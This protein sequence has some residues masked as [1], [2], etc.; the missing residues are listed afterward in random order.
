MFHSS[1]YGLGLR[2]NLPI[3]GLLACDDEP[4]ARGSVDVVLNVASAESEPPAGAVP[5][6]V[7]DD[8]LGD[9]PALKLYHQPD[10]WIFSYADGA[11]FTVSADGSRIDGSWPTELTLADA[12]VY[13]LGPVLAFVLRLRNVF[14]LHAGVFSIGGAAVAVAGC[15]EAGKSTLLAALAL[16]GASIASDDIAALEEQAGEFLVHPGYPRV[17][18]WDDSV[19]RLFGAGDA[20]PLLTPN[21]EK[22]YLDLGGAFCSDRLPLVA[23]VVLGSRVGDADA[24]RIRRLTGREAC[25]AVLAHLHSVWMLPRL[26]Q[27]DNLTFAARLAAAVPILE[28]APHR[29]PARL[30]LL[31]TTVADAARAV[32]A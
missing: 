18:L 19:A 31:C 25:L 6:Y 1:V 30:P 16:S 28:V 26:P 20:L 27:Q 24:P 21:W 23:V 13:L 7:S 9:E 32:R 3:P 22:R 29:D 5:E 2:S 4:A 17:R 14:S 8:R 10:R 11:R 15:A 12:A